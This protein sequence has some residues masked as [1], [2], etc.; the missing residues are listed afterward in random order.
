MDIA[1][2]Q[3][4]TGPQGR[5]KYTINRSTSLINFTLHFFDFSLSISL[6]LN[7]VLNSTVC[8]FA[9]VQTKKIH[10]DNGIFSS[11]FLYFLEFLNC[12]QKLLRVNRVLANRTRHLL[13]LP[14]RLNSADMKPDRK[15]YQKYHFQVNKIEA[16]IK[17]K[18]NELVSDIRSVSLDGF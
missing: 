6:S 5:C 16:L 8:C 10:K 3:K 17:D 1:Q 7:F 12:V 13:N 4:C 14:K 9:C 2:K 11:H 18:E 15:I